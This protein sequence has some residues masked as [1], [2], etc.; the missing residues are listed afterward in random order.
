[1]KF[2][3]NLIGNAA[4]FLT[5]LTIGT[6]SARA[7]DVAYV[8]LGSDNKLVLV[9]IARDKVTGEVKGLTNVHGLAGTPDGKFLI[10]G[11]YDGRERGGNAPA[12][13]AGVSA[14]EHAAH[15]KP[16]SNEPGAKSS[17]ISTLTIIST[18]DK[19]VVRRIDVPGVVHHVAASPDG[20]FAAVT[21]P[22]EDS[23]SVVDLKTYK[24]V[25]DVPT[26]SFPNYA[27]FSPDSKTVYVSNAG[28]GTVS[29]VDTARWIVLWN[30]VVGAAPEHVVLSKDGATLYVNNVDDGSVSVLDTAERKVVK[31]IPVGDTPHGIDLSDDGKTLFVAARG[32]EKV[33]AIDLDTGQS[34][35]V[36]LKPEPYHLA[37]IRGAGK[38]YVTSADAPKMWVVDQKTLNV[39]GEVPIGGK[40][41]QIVQAPDIHAR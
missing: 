37:A 32:N 11:S 21:H 39:S 28:N 29:A 24:V 38:L 36:A 23:I 35:S 8:P 3:A 41:H 2:M 5:V 10:A 7:G 9:D 4:L 34:R 14:D 20:R 6:F 1:M 33:T 31:T 12:K 27:E 15:H 19:S 25:A 17:E 22:A 18:A 16:S 13:P 26:G 30:A 40:G